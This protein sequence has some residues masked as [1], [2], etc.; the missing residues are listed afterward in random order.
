MAGGCHLHFFGRYD[1][2]QQVG[3]SADLT[4]EL[5]DNLK[6]AEQEDEE[7]DLEN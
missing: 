4:D 6:K 2:R 1:Y 5:M 3:Q 7:I